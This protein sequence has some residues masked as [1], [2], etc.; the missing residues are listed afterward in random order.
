MLGAGRWLIPGKS[1]TAD[2]TASSPS[3]SHENC[4]HVTAWGCVGPADVVFGAALL[5]SARR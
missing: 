1:L 4:L 2:S 5:F 3:I